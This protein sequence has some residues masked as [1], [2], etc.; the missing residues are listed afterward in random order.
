MPSERVSL[1]VGTDPNDPST[2]RVIDSNEAYDVMSDGQGNNGRPWEADFQVEES[3]TYYMAVRGYTTREDNASALF[4]YG[5]QHSP[6]R[7]DR[8]HYHP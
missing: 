4:V 2:F 6:C 3:G 8:T 1:L 5:R 7:G